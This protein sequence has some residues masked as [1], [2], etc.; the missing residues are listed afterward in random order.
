MKKYG[1]LSMF[2]AVLLVGFEVSAAAKVI[3]IKKGNSLSWT[4]KTNGQN[5]ETYHIAYSG[6]GKSKYTRFCEPN[7]I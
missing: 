1:Y 4:A 7:L 5:K 6:I 3:T 2:A